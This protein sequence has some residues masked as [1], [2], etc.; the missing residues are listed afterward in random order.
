MMDDAV[1][2]E[3]KRDQSRN[4]EVVRCLKEMSQIIQLQK[5]KISDLSRKPTK[6]SAVNTEQTYQENN[7]RSL[8]TRILDLSKT[9]S[10]LTMQIRAQKILIDNLKNEI[11]RNGCLIKAQEVRLLAL[12][13]I[14]KLI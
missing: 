6:D 3:S 9:N 11:R 13:M 4:I 7:V 10:D 1:P 5:K 8:L 14:L 12:S 2:Q